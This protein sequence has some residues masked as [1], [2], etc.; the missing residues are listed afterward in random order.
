MN[1]K[2]QENYSVPETSFYNHVFD[3]LGL[4]K[5]TDRIFEYARLQED[6]LK[7]FCDGETAARTL[8]RPK[9]RNSS[10]ELADYIVRHW[11]PTIKR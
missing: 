3:A 2:S 11:P 8:R 7:A 9:F 4:Y 10:S 6:T 1:G 5:F